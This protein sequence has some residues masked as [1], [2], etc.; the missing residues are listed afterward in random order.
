MGETVED[1]PMLDSAEPLIGDGLSRS[2]EDTS[3]YANGSIAPTIQSGSVFLNGSAAITRSPTPQSH[4]VSVAQSVRAGDEFYEDAQGLIKKVNSI[5]SIQS[6]RAGNSSPESAS[7]EEDT[8]D[9]PRVHQ[10]Q[11]A[12][13][14]TGLVYDVRC[15]FH[16]ELAPLASR[17]D[18]HPEEPRR[19]FV[20]Y[21]AL[22]Q[23][24]LVDDNMSTRPLVDNP[25]VLIQSREATPQEICTVHDARHFAFVSGLRDKDPIEL[26]A[27]E[28]QYD[29]IYLNQLTFG[30][31]LVSAGGAIELC[32]AVVGRQVKNGIAV[33]RP[34][35]HHAERE[36]PMGFC[37]F[38]NV[39]IAAKVCQIDYPDECRKILILD[40]DVHHGNGIQQAF[41]SDPNVLY[42][43][44]HVHENGFFYPNGPYG[45]HL[46]CG[47]GAGIG[48]NV[49]IPWPSKGMGDADYLYAFQKIVM[50]VAHEFNPNVVIIA[51]GFDA[52]QGD[53]LGGCYVSPAGYAHMTHM[54]MS[55]A[56]GRVAV[57]LE[58]GYNLKAISK[59]AL[60]VTRVLMGE[61]PDRLQETKPT[62][63]GQQTV[64]MVAMLQSKYWTSLEPKDLTKTITDSVGG[65]RLHDVIRYY[66]AAK[67]FQEH[68]MMTLHVL[69]DGLSPSFDRQ[70]IV[71]R[72]YTSATKIPLILVIHD[73]PELLG[74]PNPNTHQLELHNTWLAD[75]LKYYIDW[76]AK[77]GYAVMDVNIPKYLTGIDDD[78][79]F[80]RREDV[81]E[82]VVAAEKLLI[83]IWENYIEVNKT[84]PLVLMGVGSIYAAILH[85][86]DV[87]ARI[88][89]RVAGVV[90]F[91]AQTPLQLISDQNTYGLSKWYRSNSLVFVSEDNYIYS[92]DG[93]KK[94]SRRYGN[95]VKSY[96][97]GLY[98]MLMEHRKEV[99][100]FIEE[101]ISSGDT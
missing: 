13:L 44:I 28:K 31:A 35:G 33:I 6:P 11:I 94:I 91:V 17:D 51:A 48:Y 52:A 18:H 75:G 84:M 30:A 19:I 56:E 97:R 39:A 78:D 82:R 72:N 22:C 10:L 1:E 29:S 47:A 49:N 73:P 80:F 85:L 12:M 45:D 41:Y 62:P 27:L 76:A 24:G 54:L 23:A 93:P 100:D 92:P 77:K 64:Q 99:E 59:S 53:L 14:P 25:M 16:I 74:I 101:K 95:L 81:S 55:L 89:K 42:I 71:T 63:S 3:M 50:P 69:N 26:R 79:G 60:A 57:C 83:Y 90:G 32:R 21:Q 40:W 20:I 5:L 70:L 4:D 15:R 37:F 34:P 87:R 46:H 36:R 8:E 7:S 86:L 38:D 65:E 68:A 58:G 98:G 2:R 96:G 61:P 88:L 9:K 66:Q 67:M 43:S